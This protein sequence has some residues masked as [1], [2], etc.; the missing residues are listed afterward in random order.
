[1]RIP[2]HDTKQHQNDKVWPKRSESQRVAS[3]KQNPAASPSRSIDRLIPP[4]QLKWIKS[5]E[6]IAETPSLATQLCSLFTN[7][8][9]HHQSR[10]L[11]IDHAT[12]K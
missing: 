3:G 8:W 5:K 9:I 12:W 4:N 7:K 11:D 6:K 1:M 10:G 2:Q